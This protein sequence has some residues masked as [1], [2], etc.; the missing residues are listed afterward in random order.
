MIV[1]DTGPIVTL[2]AEMESEAYEKCRSAFEIFDG[3]LLTTSAC[4]TETMHLLG[5]WHYQAQLW[6]LIM[7][8]SIIVRNPHLD[9]LVRMEELMDKYQD[10][11]MDFADASL[12]A[13]AESLNTTRIFTLDSDFTIYRF[14]DRVPFEII[15]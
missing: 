1:V 5:T 2:F 8:G 11:P 9:D 10:T 3:S 4:L 12:V 14:R 13:L 15:P 7:N 6:R